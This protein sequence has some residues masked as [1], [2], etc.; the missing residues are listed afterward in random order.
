LIAPSILTL[1]GSEADGFELL[2]KRT[3]KLMCSRLIRPVPHA[4]SIAWSPIFDIY[5]TANLL[6]QQHGA[7]NA[8]LFAAERADKLLAKADLERKA[9]PAGGLAGT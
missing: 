7:D 4:R 6:M 3:A 5:R 8:K 2:E 1:S 9:A